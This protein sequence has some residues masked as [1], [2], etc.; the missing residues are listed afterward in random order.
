MSN[1]VPIFTNF[2]VNSNAH[3]VVVL[4][5]PS[6]QIAKYNFT[7]FSVKLIAN[8]DVVFKFTKFSVNL[9]TNQVVLSLQFDEIFLQI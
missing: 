5:F 2:S 4:N 9:N 3:Q 1:T 6:N 8:E 7:D